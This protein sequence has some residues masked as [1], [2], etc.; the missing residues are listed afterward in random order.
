MNADAKTLK[1]RVWW[2]DGEVEFIRW[3]DKTLVFRW[4]A[5]AP[6]HIPRGTVMRLLEKGGLRIEGRHPDWMVVTRSV[7][8]PSKPFNAILRLIR[9]LGGGEQQTYLS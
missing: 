2:N 3:T 7:D 8:Q 5:D 1:T 6:V 9:K 4:G